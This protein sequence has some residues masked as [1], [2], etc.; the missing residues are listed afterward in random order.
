MFTSDI[1][2]S[3]GISVGIV[4]ADA[5]ALHQNPQ[6]L[7][8]GPA[9][10]LTSWCQGISRQYAAPASS[11]TRN[12]VGVS[13]LPSLTFAAFRQRPKQPAGLQREQQSYDHFRPHRCAAEGTSPAL[14]SCCSVTRSSPGC[15]ESTHT[16]P[17]QTQAAALLQQD[18]A[19]NAHCNFAPNHSSS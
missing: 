6:T 12:I 9:N 1:S 11:Q 5:L 7:V 4:Y 14:T 17:S 18:F 15:R 13:H 10:G 19:G 16:V 8:F 2:K 3:T